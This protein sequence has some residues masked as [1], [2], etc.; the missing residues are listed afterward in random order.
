M[1]GEA[2]A[3]GAAGEVLPLEGISDAV[4]RLIA[5]PRIASV[6]S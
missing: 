1:P 5:E 4:R 3:L 2:V 6:Y